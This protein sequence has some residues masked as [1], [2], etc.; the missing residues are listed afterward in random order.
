MVLEGGSQKI[1]SNDHRK[2]R[3]YGD[4]A[5]TG[6]DKIQSKS[7]FMHPPPKKIL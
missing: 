6:K 3:D 2:G 7:L 5:I 1:G 4:T